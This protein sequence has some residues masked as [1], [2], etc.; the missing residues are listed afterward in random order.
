MDS[1]VIN[2]SSSNPKRISDRLNFKRVTIALGLCLLSPVYSFAQDAQQ[3][4]KLDEIDEQIALLD[5]NEFVVRERATQ[6]L[7]AMA[8]ESIQ[9]L[10][11]AIPNLDAEGTQRAIVV[12]RSI[13][14]QS[15]PD[16]K[17]SLAVRQA[18]SELAGLGV[19][20]FSG[21]ATRTLAWLDQWI[22]KQT[23]EQFRR[24]GAKIV[25]RQVILGNGGWASIVDSITFDE[26]WTGEVETIDRLRYLVSI[27]RVTIE[28]KRFGTPAVKAALDLPQLASLSLKDVQFQSS[29]FIELVEGE[30]LPPLQILEIKYCPI[31]DVCV[32]ALSKIRTLALIML[33]GTDVTET[34]EMRLAAAL[35]LAEIDRRAGGFLGVRC[36]V[37]GPCLIT[38][39][40]ANS[41]AEQA[42]LRVGDLI[43]HFNGTEVKTMDELIAEIGKARVDEMVSVEFQ[44]DEES[45]KVSLQLGRWD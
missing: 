21:P 8:P 17:V 38:N 23:L 11:E 13:A 1:P 2:Q 20:R 10:R 42:G 12:L 37:E 3:S 6:R 26:D 19:P 44:R 33:Y 9:R 4:P 22:E 28:G 35:P 41:A 29:V 43:T 24:E 32:D 39:V 14:Q 5:A 30:R 34:G 25:S 31:D 7:I 45:Q 27:R 40:E 36:G 16:S 15:P 18:L